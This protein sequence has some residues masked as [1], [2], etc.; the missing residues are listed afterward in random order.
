MGTILWML[1]SLGLNVALVVL[2]YRQYKA[3]V[4][5]TAAAADITHA[6][7]ILSLRYKKLSNRAEALERRA[8]FSVIDQEKK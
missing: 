4:D 3:I 1:V 7:N 8:G 2:C 6:F 5:Q